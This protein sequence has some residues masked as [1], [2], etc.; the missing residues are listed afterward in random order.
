ME[1]FKNRLEHV[2][3]TPERKT[4]TEALL[5]ENIQLRKD[6]DFLKARINLLEETFE[7]KTHEDI[8]RESKIYETKVFGKYM[9]SQ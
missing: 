5:E 8:F 6:N 2:E 7:N 3:K 4:Y 9:P 1:T